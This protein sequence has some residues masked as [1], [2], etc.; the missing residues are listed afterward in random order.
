MPNLPLPATLVG[1]EKAVY[2]FLTALIGVLGAVLTYAQLAP[3]YA[4]W[5]SGA[6]AILTPVVTYLSVYQ[7]TNTP[8]AVTIPAAVPAAPPA[9]PPASPTT[10]TPPAS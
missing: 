1:K 8:A 6:V 5:V 9:T 7:A 2:G 10:G 4:K 3:A